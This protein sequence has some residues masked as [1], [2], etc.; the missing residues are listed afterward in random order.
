MGNRKTEEERIERVIRGLLKLPDNRRCINCN[1]L[2]PQY[3]CTTFSTFV[4]TNC[5]GIHREFTHR[6]KS[7]SMAK[8]TPEEVTA[9][10]SG[11]NERAKQIYFK[12]WD[13]L[14]HSYPDSSNM[15]RLRDFIKRVYVE[16]KFCGESCSSSLP[17]I[18]MEESYASKKSS[19][20]RLEF[21]GLNSS[22][23]PRNDDAS[24]RYL[25]DESRSPKYTQKYSRHGGQARSPIKFEVVD[26]RL[27]DEERRSRRLSNIESKLKNISIDG[28]RSV[29]ITPLPIPRPLGDILKENAPSLQVGEPPL[30]MHLSVQ[31]CGFIAM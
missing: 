13:P 9:L 1:L 8:F 31:A 16:R 30:I 10:Q 14:R 27:K 25:Y 28:K 22:P 17:K 24:F 21:R 12:E 26:D 15:H 3:V 19:T 5:S 11:G 20:F 29:E 6:V 7:V 4:C 2:G 23:G 18:K